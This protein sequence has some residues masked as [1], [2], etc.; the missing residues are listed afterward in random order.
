MMA[1]AIGLAMAV[2]LAPAPTL[3]QASRFFPETGY[4]ISNDRFWDFFQR[5]G[6]IRTFGYPVSREFTLNGL[7]VQI[8]QRKV[9][10]LQPSGSV[11]LLNLLDDAYMPFTRFNN[12]TV[13][14]PDPSITSITPSPSDPAYADKIIEFVR[15]YAPDDLEGYPVNFFNTFS[16]TVTYQDAFPLGGAPLSLVPLLNLEL[17]GAPTSRP[18]FD[19]NNRNFIFQR[20]QRGILHYDRT[21]GTTQWMLLADYFKSILT[22][23]DLPPDLEE[24][25]RG[26]KYYKQYNRAKPRSLNRPEQLP[27]TDLGVAFERE[28]LPIPPANQPPTV[29]ASTSVSNVSLNS[30]FTLTVTATDEAGLKNVY[31]R[32]VGSGDAELDSTHTQDCQSATQCS[33]QWTVPAKKAGTLTIAVG[34]TDTADT[35]AEEKTV[36]VKVSSGDFQSNLEK[37]VAN[38]TVGGEVKIEGWAI[39]R[40]DKNGS[41]IDTVHVYLDGGPGQGTYLGA[42]TYGIDRP[43]VATFFG[44]SRFTKSGFTFTWDSKDVSPGPHTI[45][46]LALSRVTGQWYTMTAP[47]TLVRIGFPDDPLIT[48]ETPQARATVTLPTAT[49]VG[50]AVDRNA[51]TGTGIDEVRVYLDGNMS[52]GIQLGSTTSFVSRQDVGR[53]LGSSRFDNS[54]FSITYNTQALRAG[55]HTLYVYVLSSFTKQWKYVTVEI[56][57]PAS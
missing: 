11:T 40:A 37:P 45:Y 8:F 26:S 6:G 48:V 39:D 55:T 31:W 9:M 16:N 25:A 56:T 22:G 50:W 12:S 36:E 30:S 46:V 41:G 4:S 1:P 34:A 18:A 5:R 21:T 14:G 33:R 17:S 51:E 47:V 7:K 10:Q 35:T 44:S 57:V 19:P 29:T 43:D 53:A 3:A 15:T 42:A 13:P 20:F 54:G 52:S 38:S 23:K 27:D 2:L 24:Q 49:V 32:A 28:D